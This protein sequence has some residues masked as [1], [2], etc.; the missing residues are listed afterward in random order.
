ML[1]T[2]TGTIASAGNCSSLESDDCFLIC[3]A[4]IIL[5][6]V[7][8]LLCNLFTTCTY[9]L[10]CSQWFSVIW[11]YKMCAT[12]LSMLVSFLIVKYL[13]YMSMS[14]ESSIANSNLLE[15]HAGAGCCL[16]TTLF[17]MLWEKGYPLAYKPAHNG[18]VVNLQQCNHI[19]TTTI[20]M[21]APKNRWE[22][23]NLSYFSK[24]ITHKHV[25]TSISYISVAT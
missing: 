6:F 16:T 21:N 24:I 5:L 2:N 15:P 9:L 10:E 23:K 20:V 8:L 4:H 1:H 3:R 25:Q 18:S 12:T 13:L 17:M 7:L 22:Y 14:C 19:S 11:I